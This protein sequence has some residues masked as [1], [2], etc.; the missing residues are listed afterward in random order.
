MLI[1]DDIDNEELKEFYLKL[2]TK[3]KQ[4]RKDK[5]LTQLE[6]AHKMGHSSVALVAKA[7]LLSYNKHFN[8]EHLYR[9]SKALDL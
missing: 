6:L 4:I 8:L 3:I 7:E 9:I 1:T 5:G 2:G